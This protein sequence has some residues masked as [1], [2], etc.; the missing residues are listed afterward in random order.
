MMTKESPPCQRNWRFL[1][2]ES[3]G[4]SGMPAYT[5]RQALKS[6]L[7]GFTDQEVAVRTAEKS[8]LFSPMTP[9][10]NDW[11]R[12]HESDLM[13]AVADLARQVLPLRPEFVDWSAQE[14]S[15][16][17]Y[18]LPELVVAKKSVWDAWRKDVLDE[19][20]R[21]A[22]KSLI[23]DGLRGSLGRWGL[24]L[25]DV[26]LDAIRVIDEGKPMP[27]VKEDGPRC[28]ARLRVQFIAPFA[29]EGNL[30]IG[31]L[32]MLGYGKVLRGGLIHG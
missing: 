27:L 6:T 4:L 3:S 32:P 31:G 10:A 29:I 23:Q 17:L 11:M 18:T 5:I 7:D 8:V 28:M 16:T 15:V 9:G 14:A 19:E 12:Q 21:S 2:D 24:S 13:S 30:F 26:L 20:R 25:P 1:G 22:L